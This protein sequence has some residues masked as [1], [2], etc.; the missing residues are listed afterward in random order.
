MKSVVMKKRRI[1]QLCKMERVIGGKKGEKRKDCCHVIAVRGM[2]GEGLHQKVGGI[3][4][5]AP[6]N[7]QRITPC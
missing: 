1:L 2:S 6:G 5:K 3:R 4:G 7:H